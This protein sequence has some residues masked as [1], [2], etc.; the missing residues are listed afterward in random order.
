MWIFGVSDSINLEFICK[1]RVVDADRDVYL[2]DGKSFA[3]VGY[4][5]KHEAFSVIDN[6]EDAQT[7]EDAR[8]LITH[9]LRG[10]IILE[11]WDKN[12]ENP[13]FPID[14]GTYDLQR[15]GTWINEK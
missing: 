7:A 8:L 12:R 13:Q 10:N 11:D 15:D 6:F 5:S 9:L 4:Y 14:C 2:A 3:L 1:V